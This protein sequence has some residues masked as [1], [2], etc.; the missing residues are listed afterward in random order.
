MKKQTGIYIDGLKAV[1]VTLQN[2]KETIQKINADIENKVYHV[3]EG[4]MGT[5]N[6]SRHGNSETT[7]Q[8]RKK[9]QLDYYFDEVLLKLKDSDELYFF[10]PAETKDELKQKLYQDKPFDISKLK[11]IETTD[12]MTQNQI[13]AQ[14]IEFYQA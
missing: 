1:I 4:N 10:G 8:N 5:F 7:F 9:Q 3:K 12:K 13:V 6:G 2:G 14:V 11:A